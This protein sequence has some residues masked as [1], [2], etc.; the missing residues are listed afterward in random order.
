MPLNKKASCSD[1][2]GLLALTSSDTVTCVCII[3]INPR[4]I[5]MMNQQKHF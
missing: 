1:T 4:N 3:L 5:N 2:P